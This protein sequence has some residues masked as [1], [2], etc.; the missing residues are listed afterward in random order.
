MSC[1][2]VEHMSL[3]V[4]LDSLRAAKDDLAPH[5]GPSTEHPRLP[6]AS[7]LKL[8]DACVYCG[9]WVSC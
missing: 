6:Y 2:S 3:H 8:N 4:T 7:L 1:C 5:L 9:R